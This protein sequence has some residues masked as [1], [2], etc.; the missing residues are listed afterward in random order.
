MLTFSKKVFVFKKR[1]ETAFSRIF[2]AIGNIDIG[3]WFSGLFES[4]D[5]KTGVIFAIS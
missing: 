4:P 5:L 3:R 1:Q 2:D